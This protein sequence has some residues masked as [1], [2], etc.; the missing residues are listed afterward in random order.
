MDYVLGIDSG[1][2]KYLVRACTLEGNELSVFTGPP[3]G[4]YRFSREEA[5]RQIGENLDQCLLAFGGKREDC[6]ALVCGTTGIDTPE[7]QTLVQ[8][9]YESLAG[10]RCP[11]LCLNDAVVAQYAVAGSVG[12]VVIAGTGSIAFGTNQKGETARCGG[13]PPCI[14]GDDGSG[15]WITR[16][17]LYHLSL[18]LDGRVPASPLS[19]LLS[20]RLLVNTPHALIKICIAIEKECWENPGVSAWVDEAAAKGDR[21]ANEILLEAA[22]H[23]FS[24]GAYVAERLCLDRQERFIVGVWGSAIVKSPVHLARFKALFLERFPGV[25]VRVADE[26]AAMGACRLALDRLITSGKGAQIV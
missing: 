15:T 4:H 11:V 16:K 26:D 2:T 6:R 24:L 20:Q 8:E 19:T 22:Q 5:L 17:A 10:F 7:D 14:F 23:T 25:E 18:W 13:F 12:A 21:Y 9:M 1:G 3:A